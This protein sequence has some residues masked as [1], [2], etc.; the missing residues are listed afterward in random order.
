M[1]QMTKKNHKHNTDVTSSPSPSHVFAP[2]EFVSLDERE[3]GK[4][5]EELAS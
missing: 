4:G 5:V 2:G 1:N 3:G